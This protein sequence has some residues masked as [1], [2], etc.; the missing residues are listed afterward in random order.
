MINNLII[1]GSSSFLTWI[2]LT[3]MASINKWST[4]E[5]LTILLYS[6]ILNR[7]LGA[8]F[9]YQ[10]GML[11]L[12]LRSSSIFNSSLTLC[13]HPLLY[14]LLLQF[15][16]NRCNRSIFTM[17]NKLKVNIH[18]YWNRN[19]ILHTFGNFK[20]QSFLMFLIKIKFLYFITIEHFLSPILGF[21]IKGF[22]LLLM[23]L[24]I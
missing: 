13:V 24:F 9:T 21:T 6:S 2:K 18:I 16:S 20:F 10:F 19:L 11:K 12:W 7:C 14:L 15:I 8:R 4:Q 1:L 5:R 3:L 22:P 17:F 23:E